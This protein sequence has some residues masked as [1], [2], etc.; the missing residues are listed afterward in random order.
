MRLFIAIQLSKTIKD[1]L[2]N[3]QKNMKASGVTGNY[4]RTENLHLTLA[5]IGEYDNPSYAA[6]TLETISLKPFV[7]RLSGTGTFGNLFWAGIEQS[8]ELTSLVKQVRKA[9]SDAD[10]P[11]DKK[12]FSPH[13]TLIRK[14]MC[15]NGRTLP[16]V[17]VSP[18]DMSVERISLMKS[19]RG[20][21]GMIYTEIA[22]AGK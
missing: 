21:H 10:I 17:K 5:F 11:F 13:I 22:H 18:C 6:H 2:I 14:A 20:D 15:K 1:S 19:E 9:L 8:E 16:D 3:L 12:K 4:T 7:L